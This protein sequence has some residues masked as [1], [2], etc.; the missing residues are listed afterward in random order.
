M[1][2]CRPCTGLPTLFRILFP[3][4][5]RWATLFRPCGTPQLPL[6]CVPQLAEAACPGGSVPRYTGLRPLIP[7]TRTADPTARFSATAAERCWKQISI[8]RIWKTQRRGT[9]S[10]EE[11]LSPRVSARLCL[12]P[13]DTISA[14]RRPELQRESEPQGA[15]RPRDERGGLK[16][17]RTLGF[18]NGGC[19]Q[20]VALSPTAS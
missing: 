9:L 2:L 11:C 16:A 8:A 7:G 19:F 14:R 20:G 10:Q 13:D 3:P 17:W 18:F 5:P 6:S 1:S 12:L 4:L 15:W